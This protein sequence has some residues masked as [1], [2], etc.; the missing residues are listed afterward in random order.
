MIPLIDFETLPAGIP[1]NVI[2]SE[3]LSQQAKVRI[4]RVA[5]YKLLLS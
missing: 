1:F 4:N 5:T 3:E 2:S